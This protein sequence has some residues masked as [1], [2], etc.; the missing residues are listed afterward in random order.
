MTYE[1]RIERLPKQYTA[2]ER[3]TVPWSGIGEAFGRIFGEVVA[4]AGSHGAAPSAAFAQ[5]PEM[6][7]QD[8]DMI[9]GFVVSNP[10]TP[11]GSIEAGELPEGDAAICLHVG[12]YEELSKP[13][14][15]IEEWLKTSGREQQGL[16]WEVYLSMPDENPPRT[17][18]VFPLKG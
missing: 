12:P 9:A 6:R 13:Y 10:I 2:F 3:A 16:P 15:A 17:E 8:V 14:A 18:I 1:I 4:Y 7:E 11:S 5:Y